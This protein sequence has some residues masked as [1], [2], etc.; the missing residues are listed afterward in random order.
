MKKII[1]ITNKITI[2]LEYEGGEDS[3]SAT[4]APLTRDE[5]IDWFEHQVLPAIGFSPTL[6]DKVYGHKS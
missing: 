6:T 2:T 1:G 3:F 4:R 5:A